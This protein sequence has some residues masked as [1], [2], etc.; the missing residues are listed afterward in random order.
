MVDA[1]ERI[2]S[3]GSCQPE[4][5]LSRYG[6]V[7]SGHLHIKWVPI[8]RADIPVNSKT[9]H[10]LQPS[11]RM[12]AMERRTTRDCLRTVRFL[13]E[14]LPGLRLVIPHPLTSV[15]AVLEQT[16]HNNLTILCIQHRHIE[17]PKAPWRAR[18]RWP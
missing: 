6:S 13:G 7:W 14:I 9:L 2:A 12:Q 18:V 1:N 5:Y 3:E 10:A 4:K 15:G 11:R 17:W 8:Q 16:A